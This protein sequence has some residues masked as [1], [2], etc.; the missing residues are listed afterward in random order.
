MSPLNEF[1]NETEKE[2]KE[3][4]NLEDTPVNEV[5]VS[6][7]AIVDDPLPIVQLTD[8]EAYDTDLEIED[9]G[10]TAYRSFTAVDIYFKSCEQLGVVPASYFVTHLQHEVM[11][12]SH[13]GLGPNGTKAI[14]APLVIN[15]SI[16]ELNI[17]DNWITAEGMRD[18]A[19]MLM[20]NCYISI[21]NISHN[22]LG[23]EGARYVGEMLQENTTLRT[24]NISRNDFKDS[25]GQYF[26]E[27][28]RQ[29]FRLK[30]LDISGNE[31]CELG[32]EWMGQAIA[33]NEA[34]ETLNLS[35][36]H[37]RLKGALAVCAGMKSNITVKTLDLSWNGFADEGA[38]AMGEALKTNNTL[39][40][41][42]LSFNRIS[43]KGLTMLAK[44]LEVNDTLRTLRIGDNPFGEEG[45]LLLIN[46]IFKNEK[47][48]IED[49]DLKSVRV[50]REF[51]ELAEK[52]RGRTS[53]LGG[54][55]TSF[56]FTVKSSDAS[57]EQREQKISREEAD[58][59]MVMQKFLEDKRLRLVDLFRNFDKDLSWKISPAE[60]KKGITDAEIPFTKLQLKNLMNSLDIDT[61]GQVNYRTL[62]K[63]E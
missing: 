6:E 29:N 25:D 61:D 12:M 1:S 13:H 41:L 57:T 49:L 32:G 24:L 2:S 17:E 11:N 46:A 44:G 15:T 33:A 10:R 22:K 30:E 58:P 54:S 52:L 47:S 60:F 62:V 31:F 19:D 59:M 48:A 63:E 50:N 38:M 35:W 28:L 42:D 43:D 14:A 3:T 7:T 56:T 36:N 37:L 26:A 55:R 53:S 23:S 21:L 9:E 4:D 51:L 39:V 40:W 34:I 45:A 18:I 16:L 20:E 8:E 5:K 27:A